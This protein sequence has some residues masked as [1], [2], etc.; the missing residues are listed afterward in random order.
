MVKYVKTAGGW[1]VFTQLHRRGSVM[2]GL[3]WAD[4]AFQFG[5]ESGYDRSFLAVLLFA[6]KTIRTQGDDLERL[7]LSLLPDGLVSPGREYLDE[8]VLA[9]LNGRDIQLTSTT[10]SW[11]SG[12]SMRRLEEFTRKLRGGGG[13]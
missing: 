6:L 8:V 10:A 9:K 4:E 11:V 12:G 5:F 1:G 2:L 7:F 13:A 3:S